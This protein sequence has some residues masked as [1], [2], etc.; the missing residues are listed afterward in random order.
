LTWKHLTECCTG[1]AMFGTSGLLWRPAWNT[2]TLIH[3]RTDMQN[4]PHATAIPGEHP[5]C[6]IIHMSSSLRSGYV[7]DQVKQKIDSERASFISELRLSI[8]NGQAVLVKGWR[9]EIHTEFTMEDIGLLRPALK[10]EV[11]WQGD[12]AG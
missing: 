4:A 5:F 9:P 8:S 11:Q 3:K 7:K 2:H 12:V 10:Q 6:K 1:Q